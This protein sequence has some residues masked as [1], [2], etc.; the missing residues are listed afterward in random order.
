[1]RRD[2]TEFAAVAAT[3]LVFA[4]LSGCETMGSTQPDPTEIKVSELEKRVD[5]VERR[6][7]NESLVQMNSQIASL[8]EQVRTLRGQ[9]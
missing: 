5:L 1:M 3:A 9:V 4:G 2:A 6:V 7:D 8:E